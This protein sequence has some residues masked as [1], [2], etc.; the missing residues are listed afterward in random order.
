MDQKLSP[1]TF[2]Y[3]QMEFLCQ[4]LQK[5]IIG[6]RI[7]NC[8]A[9]DIST[10]ILVLQ[11]DHDEKRLLLCFEKPFIRFHL[12]KSKKAMSDYKHPL[13]DQLKDF[14]LDEISLINQDRLL[15]LHFKNSNHTKILIGEFFPKHPNCYLTNEKGE[16]FFSVFPVSNVV[17]VPRLSDHLHSSDNKILL[18]NRE[19]E[20]YYSTLE[21]KYS[22]QKEKN[23][24]HSDLQKQLKL[25]SKRIAKIKQDLEQCNKWESIQHEGELLKANFP[26]LKKGLKEVK[27]WDWILENEIA[28]ELDPLKSP[29]NQ[30][31]DRFRKSKKLHQGIPY[32][33][34]QINKNDKIAFSLQQALDKLTTII[35]LDELEIF[36]DTWKKKPQ[37]ISSSK[38]KQLT[39]TKPYHEYISSAG[40]KIWV[41]KNAKANETLT[42]SFANGSDWW[43]HTEGYP[44]SHIVIK[45]SKGAEPDP[46]TLQDAIQLALYYSKAKQ[47][48]EAEVC[49]T[50]RKYVSRFGK[51]QIGKVQISKHKTIFAKINPTRYQ[52]IKE[53]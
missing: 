13:H 42:F 26:L 31:A 38:Q 49:I 35:S 10:F 14:I 22:F 6:Y 12:V 3:K 17:H 41:G 39:P 30:V 28:V 53:R 18:S 9:N 4:E 27:V 51:G 33:E 15:R 24:L 43:L 25:I 50:Q 1:A 48:G 34:D 23:S 40:I 21:K 37:P 52:Q 29:Q 44:G 47:H 19:M 11:K 20:N 36:K 8:L 46:E 45:T 7:S 16:I 32:L 2:S 5:Q